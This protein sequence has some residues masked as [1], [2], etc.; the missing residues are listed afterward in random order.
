MDIKTLAF[1]AASPPLPV[2]AALKLAGVSP[3]VDTSLPPDSAP[4][5]IFSNGYSSNFSYFQFHSYGNSLNLVTLSS[6]MKPLEVEI[7]V[8]YDLRDFA[9]A[10]K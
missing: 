8:V 3:S 10:G 6:M 2:I 5:F 7:D 1:A 4:A 9:V